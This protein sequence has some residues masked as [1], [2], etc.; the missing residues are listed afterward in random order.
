MKHY[1]KLLVIVMAIGLIFTSVGLPVGAQEG[2]EGGTTT[3]GE[4]E[5]PQG[6][7]TNAA[8]PGGPGFVMVHPTAFIPYQSI[9]DYAFAG[10]G[11]AL[12]NPGTA[13]SFYEAALNLPH[14]AKITKMVVYYYD[15]SS[16]Q[17]IK[18]TLAAI[19]MDDS[20]LPHLAN[21][22]TSG[23]VASNQV[24]EDTSISADIIDNQSYAYWID[25]YI[26]G[27]QST[28]LM[29]RGIRIDYSYPVNLPL[30]N[31]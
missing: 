1:L 18:V 31:R 6:A 28:S 22:T 29:I 24:M 23:A 25:L 8:V 12:Y 9:K 17:N 21:L 20:A 15:N 2:I 10:G 30:I 14:G 11:G 5:T 7:G 19:S 26:P 4:G 13:S 16:T 3:T 27:G